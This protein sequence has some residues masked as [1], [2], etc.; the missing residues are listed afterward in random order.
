MMEPIRR[1]ER[2]KK[3]TMLT[4]ME[5]NQRMAE[6]RN[7]EGNISKSN[8]FASLQIEEVVSVTSNMGIDMSCDD[9]DTF[10]ML[11]DLKKL[12]IIYIK[13]KFVKLQILKLNRLRKCNLIMN[14]WLWSGCIMNHLR[15]MTSW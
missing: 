15:Q 4:T 9:Y 2:L 7:I 8:S 13:S 5:K 6:K 11:K 10:N 3:D 14:L 12:E 1:S